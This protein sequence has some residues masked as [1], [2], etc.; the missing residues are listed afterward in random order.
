MTNP[1]LSQEYVALALIKRKEKTKFLAR[2]LLLCQN[3]I[4]LLTL[5][6]ENLMNKN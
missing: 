6:N 1:F 2:V 4:N 3:L 5:Y